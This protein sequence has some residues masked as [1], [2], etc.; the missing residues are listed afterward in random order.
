MSARCD[1]TFLTS[2]VKK[3]KS[4]GCDTSCRSW[5]HGLLYGRQSFVSLGRLPDVDLFACNY[6]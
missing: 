5:S 6:S 4:R 3:E 1:I 2:A